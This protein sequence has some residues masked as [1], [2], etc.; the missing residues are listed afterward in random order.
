MNKASALILG[1]ILS[2]LPAAAQEPAKAPPKEDW[3]SIT[4]ERARL[5][6]ER[7]EL[8][9]LRIDLKAAEAALDTKIEALKAARAEQDKTK[10]EI[11]QLREALLSEKMQRLIVL[12]EKMSP[13][14]AAA[15]LSKMNEATASQ[16]LQGM[17]VRQASKVMGQLRPSKAASLSRRYLRNDS[18]LAR[19]PGGSKKR[20]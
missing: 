6:A 3:A 2:S 13:A 20:R 11:K 19:R 14:A 18:P 17:K 4:K 15:Y 5:Q 9:Q 12:A 7:A 8:E 10:G 16:I 1:L